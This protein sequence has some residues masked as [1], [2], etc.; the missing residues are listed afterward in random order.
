[1]KEKEY[2]KKID[3]EEL[4]KLLLF[5]HQYRDMDILLAL[6]NQKPEKS[7]WKN[8]NNHDIIELF[9]VKMLMLECINRIKSVK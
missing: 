7:E 1:M 9:M 4:N 5:F 3:M 8:E 2:K 6:K